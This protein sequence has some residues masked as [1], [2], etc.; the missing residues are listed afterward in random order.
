MRI[1]DWSSDVCSSDLLEEINK[2]RSRKKPRSETIDL[3]R[4][5]KNNH[6]NPVMHAEFV[7]SDKEAQDIFQLGSV[8]ISHLAQEIELIITANEKNVSNMTQKMV[9]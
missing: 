7:L 3:I 2:G 8:V 5:M 1:S 4:Q 6:R 9:A